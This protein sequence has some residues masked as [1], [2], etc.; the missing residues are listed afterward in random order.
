MVS[1]ICLDRGEACLPARAGPE[2]TYPVDYHYDW[3]SRK[4]ADCLREVGTEQGV[5]G[6]VA[7]A[8]A[9]DPKL[10][11]I[12]MWGESGLRKRCCEAEQSKPIW[13]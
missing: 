11:P 6:R 8:E 1:L 10:Q 4:L 5:E 2:A 13:D 9:R 7:V 3:E 12:L